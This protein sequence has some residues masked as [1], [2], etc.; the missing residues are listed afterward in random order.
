MRALI[1]LI[2]A[3]YCNTTALALQGY[4][5]EK[6][7]FRSNV[8]PIYKVSV[9]VPWFG[10]VARYRMARP[11]IWALPSANKSHSYCS[12]P[13][14]HGNTHHKCRFGIDRPHFLGTSAGLCRQLLSFFRSDYIYHKHHKIAEKRD[15]AAPK[16][17][18]DSF[19]LKKQSIFDI[20][21]F[22]VARWVVRKALTIRQK[23][24]LQAMGFP[25]IQRLWL[26]VSA[27]NIHLHSIRHTGLCKTE[28]N[29]TQPN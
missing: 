24:D 7:L 17:P 29:I 27:S 1:V 22:L 4:F 3:L 9:S 23:I 8:N 16:K 6:M 2:Q 20:S 28:V 11:V 21:Y 5:T 19:V 13:L 14:Q 18:D 25:D 26:A 10:K 15:H 12:C